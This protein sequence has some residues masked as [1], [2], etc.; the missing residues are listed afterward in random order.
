[1]TA[2]SSMTAYSAAYE[3]PGQLMTKY[4]FCHELPSCDHVRFRE[5]NWTAHAM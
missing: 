3:S 4:V 5:C 1:M 2:Y